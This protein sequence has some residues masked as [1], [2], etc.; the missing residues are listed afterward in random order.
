[1]LN[2]ALDVSRST[3]SRTRVRFRLVVTNTADHAVDLYLRGREPTLEVVVARE[4]GEIAWNSLDRAVIPASLQLVTLAAGERLE[5][6]ADW[7]Q[8]V[9]GKPLAAGAYVVRASLLSEEVQLRARPVELVLGPA[10]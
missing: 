3:A 10:A 9:N 2:V 6:S 4:N 5:V 1:V 7:D 8:R